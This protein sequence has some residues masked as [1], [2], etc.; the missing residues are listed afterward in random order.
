MGFSP[1]KAKLYTLILGDIYHHYGNQVT[2]G[3][4][5]QYMDEFGYRRTDSD[6]LQNIINMVKDL[7]DNST[8]LNLYNQVKEGKLSFKEALGGNNPIDYTVTD[9]YGNET[10]F[11]DKQLD[12]INATKKQYLR[13]NGNIP[14]GKIKRQLKEKGLE[15]KVTPALL[16]LLEAREQDVHD[17]P[18]PLQ[19]DSDSVVDSMFN[20]DIAK[21]GFHRRALQNTKRELSKW[22]RD[23]NDVSIF[24][25]QT[26]KA[27]PDALE[28]DLDFPK[29]QIADKG[30][31]MIVGLS[32]LHIGA[33]VDIPQV[34]QYSMEIAQARLDQ[35][36]QKI[37]NFVS[38]YKPNKIYIEDLGDSIENVYMRKNDQS[39]SV[40]ADLATQQAQAIKQ[41]INFIVKVRSLGV[42]V[43]FTSI[44]GNHDRSNGNKKELVEGDSFATVLNTVIE[45]LA[46]DKEGLDVAQPDH[47]YRHVIYP[48]GSPIKLVHGDYDKLSDDNILAKLSLLD[49]VNYKALVGGHFH[50][51][52][53][54]ELM[55]GFVVQAGSLIGP[56]SYSE[57]LKARS[58][59]SQ[60]ILVV[61]PDGSIIPNIIKL[62]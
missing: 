19:N 52:N 15:F 60:S 55:G 36:V 31:Q 13:Q 53:I 47:I 59:V 29:P 41:I 34:N 18:K 30:N 26:L 62:D 33:K 27:I 54:R 3:L 22:E 21:M 38:F 4:F 35:Y 48:N 17:T 16:K 24:R 23:L 1:E 37:A 11:S 8:L 25:A 9:D 32:D 56:T 50:S 58:S 57:N 44:G 2:V 14:W 51:A 46:Q 7:D 40:E 5:N 39:F 61:E 42:P 43:E 12:L 10:N 6:S 45:Q 20:D 49:D 28:L